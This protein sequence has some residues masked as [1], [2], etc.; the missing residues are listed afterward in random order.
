MNNKGFTLIE[1]VGIVLILAAIFLV[2]F[3]ALLNM[4]KADEE[5][6]YNT[7]ITDLCLAGESYIYSNMED[8]NNLSVIGSNININIDELILYGNVDSD[9]KNPKTKASVSQDRLVY[10]VLQDYSLDCEYIEN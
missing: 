8:F 6:S 4:T 2:S 3:P 7:M 10:T 5:K 1:L 9:L